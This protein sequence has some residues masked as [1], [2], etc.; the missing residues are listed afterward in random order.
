MTGHSIAAICRTLAI[1]RATPY[2]RTH[3]RPAQY[4]KVDDPVVAAQIREIIRERGSYGYRRV[5]AM[6]NRAFDTGYNRKRIR[7]VME[8]NEWNLPRPGRRRSGRAHT[9]RIVR[10]SSN[11]RWCSDTLQIP[12]WNGELVELGFI[13][14]CHDR[15]AI[16]HVAVPRKYRA[17]D[18]QELLETAVATRFHASRSVGSVQF[19][20]DN[21]SIYT[22]LDTVCTAERLGLIPVTTPAYSPQSN[23]MSEAFVNTIRRDYLAGADRSTAAS[24]LEQVPN[25]IGDYNGVAPHSALGYRAPVE[26]HRLLQEGQATSVAGLKER[27]VRS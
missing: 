1:G 22:A 11:E 26:Y 20:S 14:D 23:G 17:S 19:L 7:R 15:E 18:V 9:G 25:W 24:V 21:G 16:A 8:I 27:T 6:V 4:A 2:R 3:G 12:C 13:L 5:T 10:G